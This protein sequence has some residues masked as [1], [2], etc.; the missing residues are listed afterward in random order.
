MGWKLDAV[1]S[2]RPFRTEQRTHV[3][4]VHAPC[5]AVTAQSEEARNVVAKDH[6]HEVT[7]AA[8]ASCETNYPGEAWTCEHVLDQAS[9]L[10]DL[11]VLAGAL[12]SIIRRGFRPGATLVKLQ[13]L[14]GDVL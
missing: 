10:E 7:A 1:R 13:N 2:V 8:S 9:G 3:E 12:R 4:G 6:R 11:L 5:A 14:L